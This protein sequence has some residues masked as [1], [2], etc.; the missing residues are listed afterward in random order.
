MMEVA[1]F[2][3]LKNRISTIRT[4]ESLYSFFNVIYANVFPEVSRIM[5]TPNKHSDVKIKQRVQMS[6]NAIILMQKVGKISN[7]EYVYANWA[8]RTILKQPLKF[9]EKLL[10]KIVDF[11]KNRQQNLCQDTNDMMHNKGELCAMIRSVQQDMYKEIR[12]VQQDMHK[13]MLKIS[14]QPNLLKRSEL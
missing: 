9:D 2:V 7:F 14:N 6:D 8:Y 1:E 12:S 10:T 3:E 13:E 5:L 11:V 4:Y